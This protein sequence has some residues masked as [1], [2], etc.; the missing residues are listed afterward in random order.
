MGGGGSEHRGSLGRDPMA[1]HDMQ[2][3]GKGKRS[4]AGRPWAS[5]SLASPSPA[6]GR[7]GSPHRTRAGALGGH[8]GPSFSHE[9][10]SDAPGDLSVFVCLARGLRVTMPPLPAGTPSRVLSRPQRSARKSPS[11]E[12]GRAGSRRWS[13]GA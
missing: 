8:V 7:E 11:L 4:H 6:A 1:P 2:A 13:P 5:Q 12:K 10:G 9:A 3:A